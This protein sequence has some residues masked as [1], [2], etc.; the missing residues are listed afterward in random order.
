MS[1]FWQF[2]DIQ[3][4]IF[5]RVRLK[6]CFLFCQTKITMKFMIYSILFQLFIFCFVLSEKTRAEMGEQL[7]GVFHD[8]HR[9][10]VLGGRG[11]DLSGATSREEVQ[12]DWKMYPFV[13]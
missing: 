7:A 2:F 11:A 12:A 13:D 9:H 4:A 6:R 3:L 1:S 10:C 5:W 8:R